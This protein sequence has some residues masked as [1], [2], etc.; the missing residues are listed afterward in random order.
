MTDLEK[1]A[2]KLHRA[3]KWQEVPDEMGYTDLIELICDAISRLYVISGRTFLYNDEKFR[4]DET[5]VTRTWADNL[6]ADEIEWILVYAQIE[7]YKMCQSCVDNLTS[8]STDAMS[9]THGDKPYEHIGATIDRLEKELAV[10]W[11]RMVR[12]NQLG[13]VG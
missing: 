6:E 10:I 3:I 8:Y 7:F 4:I 9:V 11:T 12:Y 13:V 2:K 5:G 1:I